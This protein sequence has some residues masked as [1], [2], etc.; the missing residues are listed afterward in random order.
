MKSIWKSLIQPKIDYC[1]Q[2][3]SPGDQVSINKLES[4]QR[5]FTA[6]VN[7]MEGLDYWVRL[8]ELQM[9]SQE[10]RR[11]RYIII[12]LWKV[13]Q[14]LVKGYS[15]N[16]S[17][18]ARRGRL[19]V[20]KPVVKSAPAKVR[21]A[22]EISLGVKGANLFNLLPSYLRDL[23]SNHVDTFKTNLDNFLSQIPDQPTVGGQAR[24]ALS[25][26][27]LHQIPMT[28]RQFTY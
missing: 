10:R 5:H 4:V 26:S 19:V 6:K 24:A 3:W 21:H 7:G 23:N 8:K 14:G 15:V 11:E 2:L 17:E 12:F 18:S 28:L 25:N 13:T 22:K 27:L 16:V 9:Y 1:S 20:P